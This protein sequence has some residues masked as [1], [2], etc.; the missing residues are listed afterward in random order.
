MLYWK[1]VLNNR[2]H[3]AK[4]MSRLCSSLFNYDNYQKLLYKPE[5]F[6][7]FNFDSFKSICYCYFLSENDSLDLNFLVVEKYNSERLFLHLIGTKKL[8]KDTGVADEFF[9]LYIAF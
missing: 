9:N 6:L 4:L 1:V 8:S 3:L 2:L 5:E 7:N